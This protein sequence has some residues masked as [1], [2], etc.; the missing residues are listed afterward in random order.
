MKFCSAVPARSALAGALWLF[1]P[2]WVGAQAPPE[3]P[4]PAPASTPPRPADAQ[5]PPAPP[6]AV[7]SATAET[8]TPA[9]PPD[10][11]SGVL[12]DEEATVV[13]G[14]KPR[15]AASSATVRDQDFLLR[16]HRRPADLLQV[17]PGLF[18]FQH[19]GGGKANQ[20]FLRGFDI[21]H[22][23]DLAIFIDGVPANLVSHG[24][25]QGYA[26]LHWV[27]P[28]TVERVEVF[29]GPYFAEYGDFAT[30]GAVNMVT[31]PHTESSSVALGGGMFHSA[32]GLVQLSPELPG[33]TPYVAAEVY[34]TDGP[35]DHGES[36]ERYNVFTRLGRRLDDGSRLT[37]TLTGYAGGWN[38][39]GQIPNRAVDS[40]RIGRF[41]SLDPDEGGQS[42]RHS[43]YVSWQASPQPEE[44]ISAL[45]Y[46][47]RS[48]FH[49]Y[50]NFTF[51]SEDQSQ[52]DMIHQADDRLILGTAARYQ[53]A[54]RVADLPFQTTVGVRTRADIIDNALDHAPGRERSE[55]RVDASVHESSVAVY[56]EE[57]VVFAR[58]VR[59]VAGLRLDYFSF[60]V[61]DALEDRTK[62]GGATSGVRDAARA[63]PKASVI[64]SPT[65]KW[66]V[67]LNFGDGFHS[68]DARGVVRDDEAATPL[69]RARGY[70]VGTRVRLFERLDL[71]LDAF[72]IDLDSETV[73]VGDA[74]TTEAGEPSR[75]M[76]LEFEGR[77]RILPWLFADGDV[78]ATKATYTANAGN[79]DSVALAPTLT[80]SGGLS[81]RH[82]EGWYGRIGAVHIGDRPATEDRFLTAEGFTR[83]DATVGWRVGDVELAV[84]AQ[85]LTNTEWRE[86]QFATVA[87]LD[88]EASAASCPAGT[89][90][91]TEDGR[92]LGCED[93]D[94]T[95]GAPFNLQATCTL[96]F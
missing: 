29:K 4:E 16:P 22:G 25:G 82:E 76:G 74:G 40:G 33:W 86:A 84:D 85:N 35:F 53:F 45:A 8:A 87:R 44:T 80:A 91:A 89:R 79:A 17:T 90:A 23:T 56:A 95:P 55:P 32:R 6:S 96:Y 28:E 48:T 70:E 47:V 21:D 77:V 93:V 7:A 24:H 37:L 64:F 1:P 69:T 58:W 83:V 46:L 27:I 66:D 92:F 20:Y 78:T 31:R 41:G 9:A 62:G 15:T 5:S 19:A 72:R 43:A 67:Y 14:R 71:A 26:D 68:N 60:E 13:V 81:A 57:E 18:V 88:G 54:R 42:Q 2:G 34:H 12:P 30:A 94:Y 51:F 11:A 52:G 38:A 50:S 39:S 10:E 61:T 36:L 63:S 65:R 73:W 49:L 59:A 3:T 75:R